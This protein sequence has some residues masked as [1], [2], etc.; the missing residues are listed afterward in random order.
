MAGRDRPGQG[1]AFS[2]GE[3]GRGGDVFGRHGCPEEAIGRLEGREQLVDPLPPRS[4][5]A[6]G[7][8]EVRRPAHRVGSIQCLE[9]DVPF[10]H[11]RTPRW[12]TS[13]CSPNHHAMGGAAARQGHSRGPSRSRSSQGRYAPVK[14]GAG[15]GPEAFGR[16]RGEAQDLGRLG[17]GQSGEVTELD[18]AGRVGVFGG[19]PGESLVEIEQVERVG[20]HDGSELEPFESLPPASATMPPGLL[21]AG[22]LDEDPPH[23]LGGGGEEVAATVPWSGWLA[24][25]QAEIGLV[26]QGGRLER[27]AGPLLGQ[28][29]GGK[30]AQLVVDHREELPGRLR[31]AV[32]DGREDVGDVVHRRGRSWHGPSSLPSDEARVDSGLDAA[33]RIGFS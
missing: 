2:G 32:L 28:P 11:G 18:Q 7:V 22:V 15:V 6:A 10:D 19:Q 31:V 5:V 12:V 4:V 16:S 23:G 21:A 33:A 24:A 25:D 20:R 9:E 26:D 13:P 29:P 27:L 3:G 14:V 8:I 30:L 1:A 17:N